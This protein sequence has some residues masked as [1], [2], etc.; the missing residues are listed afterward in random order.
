[1]RFVEY[2]MENDESCRE[3]DVRNLAK[4][5]WLLNDLKEICPGSL[6]ANLRSQQKVTLN[7]RFVLQINKCIDIGTPAYQQYLKLQKVNTENIEATTNFEEKIS[8]HRMIKLYLTDGVQEVS[9]I[10]YRPMRNLSCDITPGCKMLI[11][12]PIE[13][14]RGMFLLTESNIELLG[15]EVQELVDTNSLACLL[16]AKL[17]LPVAVCQN[18]TIN[19]YQDTNATH[20]QITA[21]SYGRNCPTAEPTFE[22]TFRPEARVNNQVLDTFVVNN[23]ELDTFVEDDIDVDQLAAIEAQ[24]T[25]NPGK[26]PLTD[27]SSN[28]EKKAKMNPNTVVNSID[29]YPEDEDFIIED[30]DYIKEMEAK[31][32]AHDRGVSDCVNKT[33]ITLPKEPFVYIKQINELSVNEKSGKVFKVKGQIMKLLSKLSVGK[34]GWTLK[35]AIVDGTGSMDVDFT[36]DVLSKL[37]GFTPLEMNQIKKQMATKPELK[38][39]AVS[40]LQKAKECLQTLYCIIELTMLD[41]P[42]ITGLIPFD[43]THLDLLKKRQLFVESQF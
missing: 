41:G 34:D 32:D 11:K 24:F 31:F 30:E 19:T 22:E 6:P 9:A 13:C 2:L 29:E 27:N 20:A 7:G 38:E 5:Q 17:H 40:A 23:Q 8:S 4:E 39:K 36:S 35:C 28:P 43:G 25:E 16:S 1:M 3:N 14:R 21:S 10:E 33:P 12:G 18:K 15:G 26:R 37:V 42:K